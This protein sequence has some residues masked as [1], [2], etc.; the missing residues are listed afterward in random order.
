MLLKA[1]TNDRVNKLKH[2]VFTAGEA[3]PVSPGSVETELL[4]S[5]LEEVLDWS[6]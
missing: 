6:I 3:L 4:V 5:V 1:A 2:I